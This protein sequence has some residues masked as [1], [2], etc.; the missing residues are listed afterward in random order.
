MQN[1]TCKVLDNEYNIIK[2]LCRYFFCKE[3]DMERSYEYG[4]VIEYLGVRYYVIGGNLN[5]WICINGHS[6]CVCLLPKTKITKL[7][8]KS[9]IDFGKEIRIT[10]SFRRSE[11][12]N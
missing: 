11:N 2:E 4:D 10:T 1:N 3:I 8:G 6:F 9:N 12:G 7:I 5:D